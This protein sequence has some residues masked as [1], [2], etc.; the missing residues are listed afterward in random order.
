MLQ[1]TECFQCGKK[2]Q[3]YRYGAKKFC[4]KICYHASR[5]DGS[6]EISCS[7]CH[8]NFVRYKS[9]NKNRA[10]LFCSNECKSLWR[11]GK[12]IGKRTS[13]KKGCLCVVCNGGKYW[14]GKKR[15][16]EMVERIRQKQ[17]GK[18]PSLKTKSLMSYRAKHR[19]PEVTRKSLIRAYPSSLELKTLEYMKQNKLQYIFT[20]DGRFLI[21][22]KCPDFINKD[23]KIAVE[24]FCRRH[25]EDFRG[26]LQRWKR[27]RRNYFAK[28]GWKLVFLDERM[29]TEDIILRKLN[30]A[31]ESIKNSKN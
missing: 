11:R 3:T 14:L 21:G 23:K 4:S 10:N 22:R 16:P 12:K 5:I 29:I 17:F 2:I 20:A 26:G 25:K 7:L 30:K 6:E 15:D 8:K 1:F 31:E 28:R 9:S 24:V 13:H 27:N 18:H 19:S